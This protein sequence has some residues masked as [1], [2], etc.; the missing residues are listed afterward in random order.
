MKKVFVFLYMMLNHPILFWRFTIT[1]GLLVK[2]DASIRHSNKMVIGNGVTIGN[3][4]RVNFY[5]GNNQ[6]KLFIGDSC[7]FCN[8]NTFLCGGEINIEKNVLIAS[9][10]CVVSENH[11]IDPLSDIPFKDQPLK[12]GNVSIGEGSWIG[13]KVIILPDVNI[14]KKCVIGAGSVVTKSIPDFSIAVGNPAKVIKRYDIE[15]KM[16]QRIMK[17]EKN[18]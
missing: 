9:D 16:W 15:T 14:G 5:D 2:R 4:L 17:L 7:Y 18:S 6:K 11:S 1:N 12:F 10:V 3:S 13:E 8:R